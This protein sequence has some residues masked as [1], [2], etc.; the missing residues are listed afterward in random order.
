MRY[1][2]FSVLFNTIFWYVN[3]SLFT[4]EISLRQ[5]HINTSPPYSSPH[6][7]NFACYMYHA[8]I[9]QLL[10]AEN[11]VD[12][13]SRLRTLIPAREYEKREIKWK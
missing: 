7:V 3:S 9:Q 5:V 2:L 11:K 8:Q 1:A 12:F 6:A 10:R 4:N 13:I